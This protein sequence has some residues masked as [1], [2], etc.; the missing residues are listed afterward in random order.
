MECEIFRILLKQVSDHLSVIF[1]F[2]WL[3]LWNANIFIF[4]RNTCSVKIQITKCTCPIWWYSLDFVL[5]ILLLLVLIFL[6]YWLLWDFFFPESFQIQY[7]AWNTIWIRK[8]NCKSYNFFINICFW[9]ASRIFMV[10]LPC[11]L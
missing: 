7:Y 4:C 5:E 10:T 11:C 1:R 6:P 8:N 2:A 3:C 9:L